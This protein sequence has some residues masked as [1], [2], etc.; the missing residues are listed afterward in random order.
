MAIEREAA[1]EP[2][3]APEVRA[4]AER[5]SGEVPALAEGMFEHLAAQIPEI[6][7]DEEI[8]GLTLAS[9]ASNL[10]SA[11]SMLRHGIPVARTQ[12]PVAALEHAR[13]MAARGRS[14]DT[15]LRFYRL[16]LAWF[17]ELWVVELTREV[18]GAERLAEVLRETAAFS[19][20][21]TDA[22]S[23]RVSAELL[24]E[25][26]RRERRIAA[27]REELVAAIVAG[28]D[29]DVARA[30]RTLG[31]VLGPPLVAFVC[32]AQADA[33]ELE[34][35]AAQFAALL[36][37]ARPLLVAHGGA[38]I[39][40]W[41][42]LDVE[43]GEALG[44]ETAVGAE[45]PA[46]IRVA[47]GGPSSGLAGFRRSHD[48]ARRAQ[49]LVDLAGDR[50]APVTR[51]EEVRLA[52]LL[53]RDLPAA[54]AFVAEELGGLAGTDE[55]SETL[56]EFLRVLLAAE[57]NAT[58]A[59]A[60]LGLHRNTARQRLARAEELRG[61]PVTQGGAELRAAL[62]LADTLGAAVLRDA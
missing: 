5:L 27:Q 49:R 53:S 41:Q 8:R 18:P 45:L 3:M 6:G 32:W 11:L 9:C 31:F 42:R 21:Y 28:E 40:G 39:A 24:A 7:D 34:R 46:G 58:S 23:T 16:G 48:E 26:D 33:P 61:R 10:E 19:F 51:F 15:T 2:V 35:A 55:R 13:Y 44:R 50:G 17:W 30:E 12:A 25:R 20:A 37:T 43:E 59:A 57:G 47:L 56:R 29:V 22:V 52:D 4:I 36:G 62:V 1:P 54:R 60:A 38:E 14:I